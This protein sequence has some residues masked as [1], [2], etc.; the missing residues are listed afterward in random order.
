[1]IVPRMGTRRTAI[2]IGSA[3]FGKTRLAIL[4]LLYGQVDRTFY[5]SEIVRLVGAGRG[6]VQRELARLPASPQLNVLPETC[7]NLK[8]SRDIDPIS[9]CSLRNY[10]MRPRDSHVADKLR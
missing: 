5:L 1:M 3:L 6:A 7:H 9:D 4:A 10:G 2:S 8:D